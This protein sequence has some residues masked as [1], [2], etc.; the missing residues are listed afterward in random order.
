M[1]INTHTANT[2]PMHVPHLCRQQRVREVH[3]PLRK[4]QQQLPP[5]PRL[6]ELA[7]QLAQLGVQGLDLCMDKV[8]MCISFGEFGEACV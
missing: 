4:A 6:V 2:Q 8:C 7:H 5:P 1:L 3:R